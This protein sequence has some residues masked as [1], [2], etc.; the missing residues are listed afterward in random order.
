[1]ACSIQSAFVAPE[2]TY[3]A[4]DSTIGVYAHEFGHLAFGLPDLYDIDYSGGGIGPWSLMSF[5]NWN[6]GG[7]TPAQLD[8]WSKIQNGWIVPTV[9]GANGPQT[10]LPSRRR[11]RC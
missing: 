7:A 1:M 11:H 8:A 2:Y 3:S 6:N 9:V 4:G 10:C 5:G